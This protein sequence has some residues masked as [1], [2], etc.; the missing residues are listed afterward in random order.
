M[1][2]EQTT[3]RLRKGKAREF[4]KHSDE[5]LKRLRRSRGFVTQIMMRNAD[6]P[7]EYRVELRWVSREYRDRFQ[8]REESDGRALQQSFASLLESPPA[9]CL[10]EYV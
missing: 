9:H 2:V 3:F 10:L 8:A 5:R 1:I 6:D 7:G 4:E